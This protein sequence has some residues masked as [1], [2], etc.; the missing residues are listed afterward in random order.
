M[1]VPMRINIY[2][3]KNY[4]IEYTGSFTLIIF[5]KIKVSELARIREFLYNNKIYCKNIIVNSR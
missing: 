5:N 3:R 1:S 4:E 2:L